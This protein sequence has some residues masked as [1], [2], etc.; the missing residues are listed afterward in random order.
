[1]GKEGEGEAR[2]GSVR[3]ITVLPFVVEQLHGHVSIPSCPAVFC[4]PPHHEASAAARQELVVY[5]SA[6]PVGTS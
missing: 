5:C 4:H 2:Q 3:G 1:M 6:L